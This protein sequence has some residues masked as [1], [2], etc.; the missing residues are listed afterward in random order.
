MQLSS[1]LNIL[2]DAIY[3]K[4]VVDILICKVYI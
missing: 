4:Y 2:T 1:F 3:E